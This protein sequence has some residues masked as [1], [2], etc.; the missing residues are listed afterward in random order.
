MAQRCQFGA[1]RIDPQSSGYPS[2]AAAIRKQTTAS[3]SVAAASL[4]PRKWWRVARLRETLPASRSICVLLCWAIL[5]L[6]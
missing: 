1:L 5:T 3:A 4:Q 2:E 6:S